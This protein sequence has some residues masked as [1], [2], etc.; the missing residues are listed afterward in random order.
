MTMPACTRSPAVTWSRRSPIRR[1]PA[2]GN[3]PSNAFIPASTTSS[4]PARSSTRGLTSRPPTSASS[5]PAPAASVSTCSAWG[6][7]CAS[8]ATSKPCSTKS[9]R[10]TPPRNS[11]ANAGGST[12]LTGKLVRVRF[13][14]DQI[15]PQYLDTGDADWLQTADELIAIF[16]SRVGST[17]GGLEDEIEDLFGDLP[18]PQ[19]HQGL[20]KILEDRC[21]FEVQSSLPP[22]DV[23][24]AVFQA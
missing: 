12:M 17:R 4:S 20:A 23:R 22:E 5:C 1:K 19:I 15:V 9:S 8:S 14:R 10:A 16:R 13:S 7:S 3:T 6:G 21:D 18:Q 2:N 11:P 24:E